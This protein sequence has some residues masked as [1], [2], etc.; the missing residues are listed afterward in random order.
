VLSTADALACA[1][2]V[3]AVLLVVEERATQQEEL[4]STVQMLDSTNIIGTVLNKSRQ[5][6]EPDN[7]KPVEKARS[8]KRSFFSR[9]KRG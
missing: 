7:Q 2:W 1:P 9:F 6:V 5:T 4:R 3:D 8:A